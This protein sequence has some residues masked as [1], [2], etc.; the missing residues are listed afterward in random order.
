MVSFFFIFVSFTEDAND[1]KHCAN[2]SIKLEAAM[3][4]ICVF[5]FER[6]LCLHGSL[7]SLIRRQISEANDDIDFTLFWGASDDNTAQNLRYS[8]L[9]PLCFQSVP[10]RGVSSDL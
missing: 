7:L 6:L 3:E 1:D 9:A 8:S 5:K 4:I 2:L 10:E